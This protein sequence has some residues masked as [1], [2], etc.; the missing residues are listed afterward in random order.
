[1][2][3]QLHDLGWLHPD[4]TEY[5][6]AHTRLKN[7]EEFQKKQRSIEYDLTCTCN[8]INI[9]PTVLKHLKR[10]PDKIEK[11]KK[12]MTNI[13]A[14]NSTR[15]RIYNSVSRYGSPLDRRDLRKLLLIKD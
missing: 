3:D 13:R 4:S 15:S 7:L 5:K 14:E 8:A 1:M 10:Y 6:N 11:I 12:I 2:V 9:N